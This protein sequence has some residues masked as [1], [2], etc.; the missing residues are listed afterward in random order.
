[1]CVNMCLSFTYSFIFRYPLYSQTHSLQL[2]LSLQLKTLQQN[3]LY[4]RSSPAFFLSS[5]FITIILHSLLYKSY[6]NITLIYVPCLYTVYL[7]NSYTSFTWPYTPVW[8]SPGV[9]LAHTVYHT[10]RTL[11]S[12]TPQPYI[13][14]VPRHRLPVIP[15]VTLRASSPLQP[16]LLGPVL[17]EPSQQ[18]IPCPVSPPH[19]PILCLSNQF[20]PPVHHRWLKSA[21]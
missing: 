20:S 17:E 2:F 19:C 21:L 18:L 9:H 15:P 12:P 14:S 7:F 16:L 10:P 1:M 4:L 3:L 5:L 11:P 8:L 6:T 13:Y